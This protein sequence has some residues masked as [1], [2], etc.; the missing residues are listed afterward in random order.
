MTGGARG[1]LALVSLFLP[2]IADESAFAGTIESE[3][4]AQDWVA[5]GLP[6]TNIEEVTLEELLEVV[7]AS[8]VRQKPSEA[9][10]AIS[11]ITAQQIAARG[12]R[13]VAEVISSLTGIDVLDDHVLHN[14][15]VR[16]VNS[17]A[18][19]WS[20]II[21]LMIDG[22]PIS[23]RPG[24]ENFLGKELIPLSAID[25]VEIIK[26][27]TSALYGANAFLGVINIIT[28]NGADLENGLVEIGSSVSNGRISYGGEVAVGKQVGNFDFMLTASTGIWDRSGLQIL[29][30]P[31][32]SKYSRRPGNQS[33]HDI[34]TPSSVFGKARYRSERLGTLALDF[35]LQNLDSKG[36]FMDWGP[37]EH[38]TRIHLTNMYLRLAYGH[39]FAGKLEGKFSAT[40]SQGGPGQGD[41]LYTTNRVADYQTRK[42][43]YRAIDVVTEWSYWFQGQSSISSGLDFSSDLHQKLE[44][45][46]HEDGRST[47]VGEPLGTKRFNNLGA[48]L[49]GIVHP[50]DKVGLTLGLRYD[51]HS[52]YG[53]T[54]NYRAALVV[55]AFSDRLHAKLLFGTSFKAPSSTQLYTQPLVPNDMI[56]SED[57]RPERAR[58]LETIIELKPRAGLLLGLAAFYNTIADKVEIVKNEQGTNLQATNAA[59]IESYGCEAALEYGSAH[60]SAFM[61]LSLQK[62]TLERL[63]PFRQIVLA[64]NTRIYPS[65]MAKAGMTYR[66]PQAH[67]QVNLEGKLLGPRIASD[68]NIRTHDPVNLQEYRLPAQ[69]LLD[70]VLSS[71]N[72]KWLGSNETI[73]GLKVSN[74]LNRKLVFPGYGDYDIPGDTISFLLSLKQQF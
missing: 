33:E 9:P 1:W 68:Q 7:S 49:Q 34:A 66:V 62:S 22:Q 48:Y 67:L 25:R 3:A 15:G 73:I 38:N 51:L 24:S 64:V 47:P 26:G 35:S 21:K 41:R 65:Y 8:R 37:L 60:A 52:I 57:L 70:F 42:V 4:D 72:L 23:F 56:G 61:N 36:E 19:A 55:P 71:T 69:F 54:L 39:S 63:D 10:A 6:D 53:D 30:L 74:L 59:E 31:G 17:G 13:N 14:V 11:V 50:L 43:G 29:D 12:Y 40:V 5:E 16:G 46:R 45:F 58:S 20:R 18:R 32:Q 44:Y 27:P 28:R 2:A